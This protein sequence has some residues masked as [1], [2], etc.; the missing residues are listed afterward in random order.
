MRMK[1]LRTRIVGGRIARIDGRD[2]ETGPVIERI[3]LR[4]GTELSF[5]WTRG[6]GTGRGVGLDLRRDATEAP[7]SGRRRYVSTG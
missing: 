3:V 2:A 7:R 5:D 1:E 4:D 6:L